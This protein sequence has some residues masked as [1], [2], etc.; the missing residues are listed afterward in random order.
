MAKEKK[1]KRISTPLRQR[2]E[3]F[4]HLPIMLAFWAAAGLGAWMLHDNQPVTHEFLGLVRN[5]EVEIA[6]A[7]DGRIETLAIGVLIARAA[8]Q[9]DLAHELR[10]R[11]GADNRCGKQGSISFDRRHDLSPFQQG[12][13]LHHP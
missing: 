8:V 1:L 13:C 7:I 6:S 2:L 11:H 9:N 10:S 5:P 4:L 12:C 3:G